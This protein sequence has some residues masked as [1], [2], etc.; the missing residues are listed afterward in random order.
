MHVFFLLIRTLIGISE[1]RTLS[2]NGMF[3]LTAKGEED[4]QQSHR[5]MCP[6]IGFNEHRQKFMQCRTVSASAVDVPGAV[7]STNQSPPQSAT[8]NSASTPSPESSPLCHRHV[9][10]EDEMSLAF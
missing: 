8:A 9:L 6:E 10:Q 7:S 4:M 5:T 3:L 1:T 2:N